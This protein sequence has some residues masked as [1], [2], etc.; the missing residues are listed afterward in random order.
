M[1]LILLVVGL[2]KVV[3]KENL[4]YT[5]LNIMTVRY[6]SPGQAQKARSTQGEVQLHCLVGVG[7]AYIGLIA[8]NIGLR[9][10]QGPLG[11]QC[12][13]AVP[14]F[15]SH[16][17]GLPVS[18]VIADRPLGIACVVVFTF[19]MALTAT[20]AEPALNAMGLTIEELSQGSFKKALLLF[21]VAVGVGGGVALGVLRMV[22][23]WSLTP[24]LCAGYALAMALTVGSSIEFVSVAWDS[25]GVT[26][27]S[28]T[29]PLVLAM[30]HAQRN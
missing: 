23:D 27:S 25:A 5:S 9:Y 29:V 17:D 14:A 2:I 26:T 10:G 6:S 13:A 22:F 4:P 11:D 7:E 18:P 28:I 8:F 24:M 15:Y 16:V 30:S 19:F 20:Y 3:M 21:A 1:P 12:G